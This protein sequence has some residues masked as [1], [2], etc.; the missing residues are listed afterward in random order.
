MAYSCA[1]QRYRRK[2]DRE[3]ES[4][5]LQQRGYKPSVPTGEL[6]DL[7]QPVSAGGEVMT[8]VAAVPGFEGRSTIETR[9]S[10]AVCLTALGIAAVSFAAPAITVVGL[11]SIVADLGGERCSICA[12]TALSA[13]TDRAG[14]RV[15]TVMIRAG[16]SR[17]L[18]RTHR[19]LD[20]IMRASETGQKQVL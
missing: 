4:G 6:A 1:S 20:A 17:D 10:W 11:K 16:R 3:S 14:R 18:G 2:W 8:I 5:L 7:P 12:V 13:P 9:G 19:L 15:A